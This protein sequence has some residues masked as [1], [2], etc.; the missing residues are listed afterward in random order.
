MRMIMK[1]KLYFLP[2]L[3]MMLLASFQLNAQQWVVY[4]GSVSP[5]SVFNWDG[6]SGTLTDAIIDDPSM[7]GN[8]LYKYEVAGGTGNWRASWATAIGGITFVARFR[9]D[10]GPDYQVVSITTRNGEVR[11]D[12][13]IEPGQINPGGT[14]I[15]ANYAA[16]FSKWHVLRITLANDS[17]MFI[18][19]DED[20]TPVLIDTATTAS[21]NMYLQWGDPSGGDNYGGLVDWVLFDTSGAY[22][23]GEGEAIPDSLSTIAVAHVGY[24]TNSGRTLDNYFVASVADPFNDPI[25]QMLSADPNFIV[26]VE[27]I[28]ASDTA[29]LSPYDVIVV[30]ETWGSSDA[31]YKPTGVLGM[32]NIPVPFAYNKVYAMRDGRGF[33]GG[34]AGAGAEIEGTLTLDVDPAVQDNPIFN[35]IALD[36]NMFQL[37]KTG[38]SD[39]GGSSRT[40]SVQYGNSVVLSDTTTLLAM[41]TGAPATATV[42]INDIPAGTTIGSETL[43]ARMITFAQNYGSIVKNY[44][45]NFT[46]AGLTLWRNAVYVLAGLVPPEEGV[47]APSQVEVGY[48]TNKDRTSFYLATA[49]NPFNDPI[50]QVLRQDHRLNVTVDTIAATDTADLSIYDVIIV[51]ETWG[52]SDAIYKPT[53]V[54]GLANIPIPFLYNKAFAFR[55]GRAFTGG[56][57]G[58]GAEIEGTLT[59][60]VDP[61]VQGNDLFK[62]VTFDNNMVQF[63]KTGA[64][65]D[66]GSSRTKAIQYMNAVV[67]SDTTT[68]LAMQTGAPATA[69]M[70]FNDVPAGTVVGSETLQARMITFAQ[71]YGSIVKDYGTNLTDAG[72]TMWRNAVLMLAGLEIPDEP[73]D[74]PDR[75][76]VG[77]FQ[78]V[79]KTVVASA[80]NPFNDPIVQM[81]NA[82][83]RNFHVTVDTIASTDTADLSIY[84]VI[85]VQ[86]TWGSSDA[87]YKPT[88]VLGLAN[89]P[90]PFLYNKAFAFRDGRGFTG[91]ATGSGAE[92]EGTLT[93]DVDPAVQGNDLFKGVT[94]DNNMVQFVKTGAADDGGSSR[95]KALQ[96]MNAVVLSDTMTVLAMQTGA[97]ETATMCFNDVPAGTVV[98]SETLQARMITFAQNY[99]SIVK[100][101]GTNLT[102]AGLTIWRNAIYM[103]SGLEVPG[104]PLVAPKTANAYLSGITV[105]A[106]ALDPAFN[107]DSTEYMVVVPPGTTSDTVTA[108]KAHPLATVA[109]DGPIDVSSGTGT[110]IIVVTAEDGSTMMTYTVVINVGTGIED[111]YAL[112]IKV[113]PTISDHWFNVEAE[114]AGMIKVYDMYGRMV[115]YQKLTGNT[116]RVEISEAGIYLLDI[117][118]DTQ[119]QVVRVV[120]TK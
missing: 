42:C 101:G 109:G 10:L 1:K 74:A 55:D 83:G 105:S 47:A 41:Q 17:S 115:S 51:Q 31:I 114:G 91:G 20:P 11:P 28:A 69:T 56:A 26:T 52:S 99:G 61:A 14:K 72:L 43:Q 70:C 117:E 58:S 9:G 18:Y 16:D 50:V 46:D 34:A 103:L 30:Q 15:N 78:N 44:G 24:F 71:N 104:T 65:D 76:E 80:A 73:V 64:A 93:L 13:R 68:I 82:D 45:Y 60:D 85:I 5:D 102:D 21:G 39:D 12:I 90:V 120:K 100:D 112:P 66:G 37:V 81:L 19:L 110:A 63:V 29:D 2:V 40:K 106:G 48:F 32:A 95:T 111:T 22:A 6:G 7:P 25:V 89:I 98:G 107:K 119:R 33:T 49:E 96:Y 59:L 108:T 113:Y 77:Y 57:T 97:P 88:G 23:P 67:L 36:N 3:A 53:G 84:D 118:T 4:D 94:F 8:K 92:I 38:A 86:E 27:Q 79:A 116:A 87:I 75:V 54:L 62:G 35:G